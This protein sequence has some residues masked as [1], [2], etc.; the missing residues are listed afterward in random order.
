MAEVNLDRMEK[1][2]GM[3]YDKDKAYEMVKA[4]AD[5]SNQQASQEASKEAEIEKLKAEMEA[6]KKEKAEQDKKAQTQTGSGTE[7]ND[8]EDVKIGT[9]TIKGKEESYIDVLKKFC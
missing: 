3:G 2:I 6:M 8:N 9:N 4:E 1:L 5:E 7:Q